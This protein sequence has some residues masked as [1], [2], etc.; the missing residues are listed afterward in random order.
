LHLENPVHLSLNKPSTIQCIARESRPP[1]KL[2]IAINGILI[3]D[4]KKYETK[5]V[6]KPYSN[7]NYMND[8][9]QVI[10]NPHSITPDEL[11]HSFYDTITNFTL[12]DV[13]MQMEGKQ[14][15][16]FAYSFIHNEYNRANLNRFSLNSIIESSNH[17]DSFDSFKKTAMLT[18]STIQV[19]C[20]S[21]F[22]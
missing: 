2:F 13:R 3:K 15:E 8:Y 11:R 5:I 1:V 12:E 6:Q 10:S 21:K 20:N 16:C 4:D 14:V 7:R 9:E 18:K 22:F 19:D 17:F